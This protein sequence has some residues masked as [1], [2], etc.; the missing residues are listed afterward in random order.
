MDAG[1]V[2]IFRGVT[3]G[4][5]RIVTFA[6]DHRPARELINALL[7]DDEEIIAFVEP[8]Q[9]WPDPIN[10][11]HVCDFPGCPGARGHAGYVAGWAAAE[12]AD[13]SRPSE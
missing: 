11:D 6:V 5:A 3:F 12:R 4:D 9:I 8:W 2:V 1:S 10:E 13:L 7:N